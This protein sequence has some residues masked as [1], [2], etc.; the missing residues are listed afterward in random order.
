MRKITNQELADLSDEW[1]NPQVDTR[2][3]HQ[4]ALRAWEVTQEEYERHKREG[5]LCQQQDGRFYV[6]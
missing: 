5:G 1:E 2:F 3:Y 4:Q 6:A